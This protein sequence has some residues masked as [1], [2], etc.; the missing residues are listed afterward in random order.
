MTL[1]PHIKSIIDC[2]TCIIVDPHSETV[3]ISNF[4]Q[5]SKDGEPSFDSIKHLYP[6]H[7]LFEYVPISLNPNNKDRSGLYMLIDEEGLLKENQSYFALLDGSKRFYAG[8]GVMF[9]Q[10]KDN[11]LSL[12]S[13]GAHLFMADGLTNAS[14]SASPLVTFYKTSA[15]VELAITLGLLDRPKSEMTTFDNSGNP[16]TEVIWEWRGAKREEAKS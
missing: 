1:G 15:D 11:K 6:D 4:L 7:T 16:K 5:P 14:L 8:T 12:T 10:D 9:F 2:V 13:G 3:G